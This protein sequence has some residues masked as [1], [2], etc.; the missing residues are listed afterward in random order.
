MAPQVNDRDI[1]PCTHS[2]EFPEACSKAAV[3]RAA[4]EFCLDHGY[5]R[6]A[7]YYIESVEFIWERFPVVGWTE[8]RDESG[9]VRAGWED[10]GE[11]YDRFTAI[12]CQ[13]F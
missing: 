4:T 7:E 1:W 6:S 9:K 2:E 5:M 3:N 11:R 10:K 12:E 8:R 13:S